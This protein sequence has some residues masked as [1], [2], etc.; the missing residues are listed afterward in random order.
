MRA[1]TALGRIVHRT[2]GVR[3]GPITRLMSPGDLG[4][5]LKPFVF[6]DRISEP[7]ERNCGTAA[8]A[9]IRTQV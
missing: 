2:S 6:L 9:G 3:H 4:E 5:H 7:P 8:S 1:D